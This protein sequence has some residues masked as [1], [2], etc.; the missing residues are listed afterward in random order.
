MFCSSKLK[1]YWTNEFTD[2]LVLFLDSKGNIAGLYI[3]VTSLSK[4]YFTLPYVIRSLF[5]FFLAYVMMHTVH[6]KAF[7]TFWEYF[8]FQFVHG[9]AL[10]SSA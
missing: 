6:Y 2:K 5:P 9:L 10:V 7:M 1:L 4:A 8:I 3:I